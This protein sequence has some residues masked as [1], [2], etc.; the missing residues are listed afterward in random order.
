M[1]KLI[2]IF[3]IIFCF[4]QNIYAW[5]STTAK[6]MPLQVGN[7]WVYKGYALGYMWNGSNYSITKIIGIIDTLG[8]KYYKLENRTVV[9]YGNSC[10]VDY[11][12]DYHPIRID[13]LTMNFYALGNYCD[14]NERKIDS[15]AS[16]LNDSFYR[17]PAFSNNSS[18]CAVI[19]TKNIFN[20]V[21]PVKTFQNQGS[22]PGVSTTY[23]SGLGIIY[24]Y[25][26][27]SMQSCRDTLKG[28]VI[29]GV[30]YGDTS[31]LVGINQISTEIPDKFSLSQNYPNPFNPSTHFGFRIAEFGLVKFTI[32][33]ALGKQVQ[34]L[35]NQQLQPGTYE[36]DWDASSYP[37]GVYY[38]KLESGSFAE[39]KKMVLLR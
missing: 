37:S 15:L 24:Y 11:L 39:T 36:A 29:N 27:Y 30:L 8:K 19:S 38:Y 23:A 22:G 5:D 32:Y 34:I 12:N 25:H 16:G 14:D 33:D 26:V 7:V 4:F 17:C 1:R 9:I 21:F 31:T 13:S 28:C 18:V 2:L 20:A 35:V 10:Q 6:Y 3:F